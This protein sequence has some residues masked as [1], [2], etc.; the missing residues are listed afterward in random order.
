[1]SSIAL[2][3]PIQLGWT[4]AEIERLTNGKWLDAPRADAWM[5][6]GICA[7]PTQFTENQM[8]LARSGAAGLQPAVLSRLAGRSRGIIAEKGNEYLA[9]GV[10]VLEVP[11]LRDA[12]TRLA[13][14][15][16]RAFNGAVIAVT[17]SVGKTTTVAMAAHALA[18]IG[19]SDRSR[20][21][22]NS[23]YGIGWNLASMR[24]DADYWVQEMAIGR[25]D[26]CSRLV[27]P[28]VAIVTAIAPAHLASFGSTDKIA[29]LKARIYEG[30]KPGGIAVINRDIPEYSIFEAAAHKAGLRTVSF[31]SGGDCDARFISFDGKTVH[32]TIGGEEHRFAL[33]AAGNHM[34][35]NAIAVL[36]AVTA[37][38]GNI[39]LA[40]DRFASFQPLAGRGKRSA[41]TYEGKRIEVWDDSFNANPA[42]MRAALRTMQNAPM[43]LPAS[44]VLILGD[45]LE[46]G[47]DEQ[48]MHLGLRADILAAGADRILFCG[49][50][51]EAVADLILREVKGRWFPDVRAVEQ[52]LKPW[53]HDGD[54]V[55]LKASHGIHLDRLVRLLSRGAEAEA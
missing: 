47:P 36:A 8:L 16:R 55:L 31:G 39:T 27:Q 13:V 15:A 19:I 35:M 46:L 11:D 6:M 18:G 20:T 38:G 10:P 17:G 33:G 25:M 40:A 43:V 45:M 24:R 41:S 28:D 12:V 51:M 4:P 23:P 42:S 44:R 54:T 53:I 50:L 30:M 34:A 48:T 29:A 32:A 3:K 49:P 1:M 37:L 21:S 22:A 52:G 5:A 2:A 26:V 7:E 9:L 14:E